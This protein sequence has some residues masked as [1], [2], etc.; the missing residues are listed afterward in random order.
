MSVVV[1]FLIF[2]AIISLAARLYFINSDKLKFYTTGMDSG[3]KF[4][5]ISTLWRLAKKTDL[6]TPDSLYVSVPALNDCISKVI[7]EERKNNTINSFKTQQFLDKLYKFRTRVTLEKEAHKGLENTRYLDAGQRL[8]IILPGKGIFVS[9][10]KNNGHELLATLPK[11]Q[12]KK[13]KRMI[14][15]KPEDWEGHKI[16]V[17]L[18]RK[19][20]ACY[21]F[22]T[23]VL[24]STVFQGETC[25]ILKHSEELDRA[26]KRQS[27][28]CVCQIYAQMYII[29]EA[30]VDYNVA[31]TEPGYKCLLEDISEDGAMIRIG[32]MGKANVQIKLQFT[33]NETFIMMYGIVRAVEYNKALDQSRLHFECVH[34]DPAMKNAI[35]TFVY[36]VIPEE[37]KERDE[38]VKL[39]ETDSE[40]NNAG[41]SQQT[42]NG[43]GNPPESSE[44][45][46]KIAPEDVITLRSSRVEDGLREAEEKAKTPE[47]INESEP[48]KDI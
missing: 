10:I 24:G 3:F 47:L 16:S 45:E 19:G 38:A 44:E 39:A 33:L 31:E 15:L 29:K 18:W 41:D 36:N 7:I 20:D 40:E 26:Q 8:R 2:V 9:K 17:Y 28:R 27:V 14:V 43:T 34:I 11:Q 22:D 12:E 30:V 5:E 42:E 32:G 1:S 6:E 4:S 21:A 46:M 35:L 25:I 48:K 37:Q 23:I 13:T